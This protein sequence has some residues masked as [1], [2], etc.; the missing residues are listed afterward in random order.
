MVPRYEFLL[1]LQRFQLLLISLHEFADATFLNRLSGI[2]TE[3]TVVKPIN[4]H[5]IITTL[6]LLNRS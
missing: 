4:L 6:Y 2:H 1:E 5:S 3:K